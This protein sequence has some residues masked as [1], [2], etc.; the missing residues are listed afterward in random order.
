VLAAQVRLL[1]THAACA[2]I[3]R[4]EV[5]HMCGARAAPGRL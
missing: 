1:M 5:G 2:S 4:T 3:A